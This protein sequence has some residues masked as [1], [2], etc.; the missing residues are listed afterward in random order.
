M[1]KQN[2]EIVCIECERKLQLKVKY[3][4]FCGTL[5]DVQLQTPPVESKEIPI[6]P[7]ESLSENQDSIGSQSLNETQIKDK[8]NSSAVVKHL[9]KQGN[10]ELLGVIIVG[11]TLEIMR[12]YDRYAFKKDEGIFVR[13]KH[14][15]NIPNEYLSLEQSQL[16]FQGDLSVLDAEPDEHLLEPIQP[17]APIVTPPQPPLT[18]QPIPLETPQQKTSSFKYI[19]IAFIVL[20]VVIF[21]MFSGKEDTE[22]AVVVHEGTQLDPCENANAEISSLLSEKMPTRALSIINLN[23]AECK[24]N[25]SFVQLVVSAEAQATS[26]KEKLALAKEYLQA[27][28]LELAH[29]TLLAAL[30]LDAELV[31]GIELLPQIESR[32]EEFNLQQEQETD[33]VSLESEDVQ[34]AVQSIP[35]QNTNHEV[36]QAQRLTQ[37]ERERGEAQRQAEQAQKER[38]QAFEKERQKAEEMARKQAEAAR[39]QNEAR[40]DAQLS[41]AERALNANNYGLA[42]SLVREVLSASPSNG[43]AKRILRQAEAGESAAFDDMVIQ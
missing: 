25:A 19:A 20:L 1:A 14:L 10:K 35:Q 21:F 32:I 22:K 29:Q 43:Q 5:H 38:Q 34:D 23:Q 17:A 31:G 2:E 37:A 40:F 11:S 9:T 41:R 3:C 27:E 42:K 6:I 28:N 24:T 12:T 26:A 4:P 30:E 16:K 18:S 13:L 39:R 36:E 7:K 15:A 8:P 33:E